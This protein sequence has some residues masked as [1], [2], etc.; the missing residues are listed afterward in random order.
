MRIKRALANLSIGLVA[1]CI[2]RSLEKR[3]LVR[4]RLKVLLAVFPDEARLGVAG[5]EQAAAEQDSR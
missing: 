1:A 4:C 3:D 5:T 2:Q